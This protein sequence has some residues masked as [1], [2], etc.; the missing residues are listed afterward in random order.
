MYV[1]SVF[2]QS[3][4]ILK[5]LCCRYLLEVSLQH[6]SVKL[7]IAP[8]RRRYPHNIYLIYENIC[9]GYSLEAI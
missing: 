8:D 1:Y 6:V 7:S 5:T 9:C 3:N 2:F 4:K